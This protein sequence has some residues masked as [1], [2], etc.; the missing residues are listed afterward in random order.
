MYDKATDVWTIK[1]GYENELDVMIGRVADD[2]LTAKETAEAMSAIDSAK[3]LASASASGAKALAKATASEKAKAKADRSKAIDGAMDRFAK[4]L[5]TDTVGG[6]S[7]S[8]ILNRLA[9][10][11]LAE[12]TGLVDP[13]A[14]SVAEALAFAQRLCEL[15]RAD[16]IFVILKRLRAMRPTRWPPQTATAVSATLNDTPTATASVEA[17]AT[18]SHRHRQRSLTPLEATAV[19]SGINPPPPPPLSPQWRRRRRRP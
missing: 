5:A 13:A 17:T 18:H 19:A 4:A 11:G 15:D 1:D 8:E 16:V 2:G 9:D 14:M 6:A 3:R 10:R 7:A 12:A